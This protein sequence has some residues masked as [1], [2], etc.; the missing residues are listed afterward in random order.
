MTTASNTKLP[1]MLTGND[2]FDRWLL[3]ETLDTDSIVTKTLTGMIDSPEAM[4]V[5][6]AI[7][8]ASFDAGR[9]VGQEDV[10]TYGFRAPLAN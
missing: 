10:D 5:T 7:L 9:V 6:L 2:E 1:V 3:T 4:V 8:E